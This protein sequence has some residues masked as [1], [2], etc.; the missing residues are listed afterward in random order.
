ME[1]NSYE[2]AYGSK[3]MRITCMHTQTCKRAVR[4]LEHDDVLSVGFRGL[5]AYGLRF[6]V[7]G[8]MAVCNRILLLYV[9][10][11]C[12]DIGLLS[13]VCSLDEK[14]SCS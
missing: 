11:W 3:L 9:F 10:I 14:K 1:A 13:F 8:L 5:R 12:S 4:E 7:S 2:E 6:A